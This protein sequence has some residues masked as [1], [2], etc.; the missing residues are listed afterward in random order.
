MDIQ[1]CL[2][3]ALAP[4][5]IAIL[6][7]SDRVG[8]L[9]T[10]LWSSLVNGE[11]KG[12]AF[13]INPKYKYLGDVPCYATLKDIQEPIDL[14]V[15]AVAPQKIENLLD[16]IAQKG[17]LWAALPPSNP[18]ITSD[19][20]WQARIVNKANHLGIRLI[21]TDCLG[22]LR[23]SSALNASYWTEMPSQGDIGFV[24]QSGVIGTSVLAYARESGLGFSSIV[25]TGD[26]IDVCMSE[27]IDFL[28][29]D[30]Q[31]RT[32]I[33]HVEGIRNPREFFSSIRAASQHKPVIVLRGGK[34][35]QS[36]Y[37]LANR[38]TIPAGDDQ[39]F[40]ALIE[41]AGA[42]R[43]HNLDELLA[44]IEAF[45]DRRHP[46]TNRMGIICNGSGFGVLA[47][48]AAAHAKVTLPSLSRT[49][50]EKIQ[51]LIDSPLPVTNPIDMGA[52]A[53]P[54]RIKLALDAL[55]QDENIDAVLVITAPS[56]MAP[57]DKVCD[58]LAWASSSSYKPL[59][60]AWIGEYETITARRHLLEK[61]ITALKSPEVAINAFSWLSRYAENQ[62]FQ[63]TAT[64]E[65][66]H[67]F[68]IDSNAA[69]QIVAQ[70]IQDNRFNLNEFETKKVLASIGLTTASGIIV[71]SPTEAVD[72]AK[73]LG[74]PVVLKILADGIHHK[75][76]VGGVILDLRT[77]QEVYHASQRLIDAVKE[78][79]PYA[80]IRGIY[81]Q[82]MIELPH[83]RELTIRIQTDPC[84]G[85][86]IRFGLGGY[87][88]E[89]YQD[90][91]VELL[92][93][94]EPLALQMINTPKIARL[95]ERF[96]GMPAINQDALRNVLMRLSTL[97]TEIPAIREMTIDPLL[98]DDG[99]CIVLDANIT[100][101][102]ISL[103]RDTMTSH[104]V[105]SPEPAV[106]TQLHSLRLGRVQLR[107]IRPEDYEAVKRFIARLSPQSVYLRF[108][109][110]NTDL[111]REKIVELTN[112][113][114]NREIALVAQDFEYPEMIRAVARYKRINGSNTA[115]FGL[116]VE[117]NWQ[118]RGLATLMMKS[119]H[120]IAHQNGI[121]MLVGYV[122]RGNESMFAL[123]DSLGYTRIEGSDHDTQFITFV[124]KI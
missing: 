94:T 85:P 10:I 92:P 120:E 81:V 8:S 88:G 102:N 3:R 15:L 115:E 82:R 89:I 43:V 118:R 97:I 48:D 91:A 90:Y 20:N 95:L 17:V 62:R 56:V 112:L 40:D 54:R 103:T 86:Y 33:L 110:S 80:L 55:N 60:T 50:V 37:L 122:L 79:A 98:V 44:A 68:P 74:L 11:F 36:G 6:G 51:N 99:G 116:I 87:I 109:I 29:Q 21:G 45:S 47:A 22:I 117:D 18:Q 46:R 71:H 121:T 4:K 75:S 38:M 76:N 70:A 73:T 53:D 78:Q 108:H 111:A 1:H 35:T 104:M 64:P 105:I 67:Q 113:D 106:S 30:S 83:G 7:A 69:R 84:F 5:S 31:T 59:F 25:N 49:T 57:V 34:S 41:R 100:V 65:N 123:M 124:K 26:E 52:N 19:Q 58:A 23:P 14:V 107:S 66:D 2:H 16:E 24:S 28:A 93:L 27:V 61:R 32:I 114:Y 13:A 119:L 42:I 77:T 39:V 12:K 96:R 101:S 72:A 63:V 9:G